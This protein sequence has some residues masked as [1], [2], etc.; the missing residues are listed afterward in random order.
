MNMTSSNLYSRYLLL[1]QVMRVVCVVLVLAGV[2]I[3]N[4]YP[5]AGRWLTSGLMIIGFSTFIAACVVYGRYRRVFDHEDTVFLSRQI[6]G[7]Q[8]RG[9]LKSVALTAAWFA[10]GGLLIYVFGVYSG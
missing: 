3:T 9:I 8:V 1:S 7:K 5:V 4:N 10:I 2:W 6:K